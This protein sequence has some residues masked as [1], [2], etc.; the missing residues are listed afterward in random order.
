MLKGV[1]SRNNINMFQLKIQDGDFDRY[2]SPTW[3][4][5]YQYFY[6]F[7]LIIVIIAKRMDGL[8]F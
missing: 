8:D 6:S 3:K 1:V 2:K 7:P 4:L 5:V